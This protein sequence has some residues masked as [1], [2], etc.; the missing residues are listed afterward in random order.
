MKRFF[1]F[2]LRGY[3]RVISPS[4]RPCCRCT[5]TCSTYAVEAIE[6]YGAIKGGYLALGRICRC[7]PFHEGGYD[8]VP[9]RFS[10][11]GYRKYKL[12]RYK[13]QY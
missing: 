1:L 7:H 12:I 5:P 9:I 4:K 6:K 10:L 13:N 8:P 11:R 2:L 3:R